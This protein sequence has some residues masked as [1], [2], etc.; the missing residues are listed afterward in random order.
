MAGFTLL[1][2]KGF[3]GNVDF[4]AH[5]MSQRLENGCQFG[6]KRCERHTK[7]TSKML[8]TPQNRMTS[9]TDSRGCRKNPKER[10]ALQKDLIWRVAPLR[11]PVTRADNT[12]QTLI[13]VTY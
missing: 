13:T 10:R 1:V 4:S 7:L 8:E 2:Q 11:P 6:K 12:L 5:Q 3:S 9:R